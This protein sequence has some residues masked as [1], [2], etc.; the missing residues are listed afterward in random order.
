M[1]TGR[2]TGGGLYALGRVPCG[3]MSTYTA[4]KKHENED[5]LIENRA[6]RTMGHDSITGIIV[7]RL[8]CSRSGSD[9]M[10]LGSTVDS[11]QIRN[12]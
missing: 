7:R 9:F 11:N 6:D 3:N 8:T 12:K 1:P 10:L 4:Y 5:I 2:D